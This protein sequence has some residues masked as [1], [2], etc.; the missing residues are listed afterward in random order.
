[1]DVFRRCYS[2]K[3]LSVFVVRDRAMNVHRG[4]YSGVCIISVFVVN[5]SSERGV[6]FYRGCYNGVCLFLL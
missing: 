6:D 5:E 4:C 1:M 3:C 2:G